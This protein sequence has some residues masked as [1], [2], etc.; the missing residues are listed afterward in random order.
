[1]K[2]IEVLRMI[3][4]EADFNEDNDLF[5]DCEEAIKEI[6]ALEEQI[7]GLQS[8]LDLKQ[9]E[10]SVLES[11]VGEVKTCN[12]CEW[13]EFDEYNPNKKCEYCNRGLEDYYKKQN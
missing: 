8:L 5:D 2:A 7:Q 11:K 13:F 10:I 12:G 1:M 3:R 4:G 9:Q 6:E